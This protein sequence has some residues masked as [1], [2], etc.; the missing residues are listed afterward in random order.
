MICDAISDHLALMI[1]QVTSCNYTTVVDKI[2]F[3]YLFTYLFIY[4][5]HGGKAPNGPRP[6]HY[7]GFRITLRHITIHRTSPDE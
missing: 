7:P 3:I 1:C 4:L 5:F 2:I 6:L